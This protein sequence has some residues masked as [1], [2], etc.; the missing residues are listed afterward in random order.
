VAFLTHLRDEADGAYPLLLE[1][2]KA[3]PAAA[4]HKA[5]DLAVA[6]HKAGKTLTVSEVAAEM[7]RQLAYAKWKEDQGSAKTNTPS[8]VKAARGRAAS[9]QEATDEEVAESPRTIINRPGRVAGPS[10]KTITKRMV[11]SSLGSGDRLVQI[12]ERQRMARALAAW[13]H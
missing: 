9:T 6:Y 3:D 1:E 13:R 10:T 7:E 12:D 5:Y 2:A 4:A 11:P 8:K